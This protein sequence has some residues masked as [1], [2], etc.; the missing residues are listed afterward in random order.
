M[1]MHSRTFFFIEELATSDISTEVTMTR[2]GDSDT[3]RVMIV[4]REVEDGFVGTE[5]YVHHWPSR[6]AWQWLNDI[7]DAA[8]PTSVQCT[9]WETESYLA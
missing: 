4:D 2:V 5:K 9:A 1:M 6:K 7:L 8:I 3:I